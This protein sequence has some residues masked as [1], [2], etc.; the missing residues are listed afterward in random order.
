MLLVGAL[1]GGAAATYVQSIQSSRISAEERRTERL[2]QHQDPKSASAAQTPKR[3][4][5]VEVVRPR[6]TGEE[7]VNERT[8][9]QVPEGQDPM[10]FAVNSFLRDSKIAP[11]GA[12]AVKATLVR[13]ELTLDFNTDFDRTYG[14]EDER[15]LV[16]GILRSLGQF[17]DVRNVRFTINGEQVETLGHLDLTTPQA[18][19]RD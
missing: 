2:P 9:V 7:V 8:K 3:G 19:L 6:D 11:E 10:L 18:V 17:K 1:V 12:Q 14:S 16:D 15:V 13:G 5:E 4:N